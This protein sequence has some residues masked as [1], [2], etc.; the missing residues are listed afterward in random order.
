MRATDRIKAEL[1]D[2]T[3]ITTN[4]VRISRNAKCAKIVVVGLPLQKH[5]APVDRKSVLLREGDVA[6]SKTH[7]LGIENLAVLADKRHLEIVETWRLG[8]PSCRALQLERRQRDGE[9]ASV[10]A[11]RDGC[12]RADAFGFRYDVAVSVPAAEAVKLH[13]DGNSLALRLDVD[14]VARNALLADGL[15]LHAAVESAASIPAAAVLASVNL[16]PDF[17]EVRRILLEY[18]SDIRLEAEI[19]VFRFGDKLAVNPNVAVEHDSAKVEENAL[20]LPS[21]VK[22]ERLAVERLAKRLED[23]LGMVCASAPRRFEHEVVRQIH[24]LP[25]FSAP[26]PP[27]PT[28]IEVG[29]GFREKSWKRSERNHQSE[30][31]NGQLDFRDVFHSDIIAK[32]PPARDTLMGSGDTSERATLA[33][34]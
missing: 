4:G 14:A 23:A 29:K 8:R 22:S 9:T 17:D 12:G 11:L 21:G 7:R 2:C 13:L 32:R 10:I 1:L 19:A 25:L 34:A 20:A 18:F 30:R 28:K 3:E 26:A 15:D 27:F 16:R 33:H 5:L 6:Q 24:R 31:E